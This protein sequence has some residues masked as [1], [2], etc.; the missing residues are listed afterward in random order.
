[1]QSLEGIMQASA[2][3]IEQK[4]RQNLAKKEERVHSVK[5][6]LLSSR[7]RS[8]QIHQAFSHSVDTVI[9]GFYFSSFFLGK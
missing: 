3:I 9:I 7:S 8:R 4:E 6:T 1:L 5:T 2:D